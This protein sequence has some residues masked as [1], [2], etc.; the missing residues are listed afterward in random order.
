MS[1]AFST[2]QDTGARIMIGTARTRCRGR[3][4]PALLLA[5]L[6]SASAL[7]QDVATPPSALEPLHDPITESVPDLD[8]YLD[9]DQAPTAP[10]DDDDSEEKPAV[11]GVAQRF[12]DVEV[13]V[14]LQRHDDLQPEFWRSD[15]RLPQH[16]VEAMLMRGATPDS[17]IYRELEPGE[18]RLGALARQLDRG[19]AY[20]VLAHVAWRQP[21]ADRNTAAAVTLPTGVLLPRTE[22]PADP[23]SDTRATVEETDQLQITR[24]PEPQGYLRVWVERFVHLDASLRFPAPVAHPARSHQQADTDIVFDLETSRRLRTGHLHY[25]DHPALGILVRV[26][27]A[28]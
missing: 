6:W 23:P 4:L 13:I 12:Y 7:A 14:F 26:D 8:L 27:R 18:R 28:E 22:R 10:V 17:L 19:A 20:T 1:S 24:I 21:A 2:A 9:G 5:L 11:V 16:A 3:V 15:R 25:I